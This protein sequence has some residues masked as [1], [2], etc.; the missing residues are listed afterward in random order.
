MAIVLVVARKRRRGPT[1]VYGKQI[2]IIG[3]KITAFISIDTPLACLLDDGKYFGQDYKDEE[4]PD[5]PHAD[6]C[7]CEISDI[8]Q[9]SQEVFGGHKKTREVRA[10]DLGELEMKQFRYYKYMLIVRHQEA[11]ESCKKEYQ[12]LVDNISIDK[13]FKDRVSG[14]FAT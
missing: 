7:K 6:N 11:D 3:K 13:K 4:A 10:T 14:H 12:E 9:R 1:V 5:L 2:P 8:Y